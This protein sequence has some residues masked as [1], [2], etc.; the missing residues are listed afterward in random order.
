MSMSI[1][2]FESHDIFFVQLQIIDNL[3]TKYYCVVIFSY[4]FIGVVLRYRLTF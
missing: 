1:A 3:M 4:M 2:F